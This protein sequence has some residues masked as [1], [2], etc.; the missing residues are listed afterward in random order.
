MDSLAS[1]ASFTSP[2]RRIRSS[3][4]LYHSSPVHSSI[5]LRARHAMFGTDLANGA[6]G[7]SFCA[8]HKAG[9]L[10]YLPMP[11]LRQ[12][13]TH[14]AFGAASC[15]SSEPA[16]PSDPS[17][18]LSQVS[19]HACVLQCP[20]LTKHLTMEPDLKNLM[21]TTRP[22]RKSTDLPAGGSTSIRAD[23]CLGGGCASS[24]IGAWCFRQRRQCTSG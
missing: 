14:I 22:E 13:D 16:F 18:R 23:A 21:T 24:D 15:L 1:D 5:G 8:L 2:S 6:T 4:S 9:E 19:A 20:E 17:H 10:A 3:P 12:S 11:A 7:A